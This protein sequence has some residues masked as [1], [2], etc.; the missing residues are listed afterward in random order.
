MKMTGGPDARIELMNDAAS[1]LLSLGETQTE[2]RL[3]DFVSLNDRHEVLSAFERALSEGYSGR[4]PCVIVSTD[5]NPRRTMLWVR[6]ITEAECDGSAG[7]CVIVEGEASCRQECEGRQAFSRMLLTNLAEDVLELDIQDRSIKRLNS[8]GSCLLQCPVNVRMFADDAIRAFSSRVLPDDRHSV[9][10]FFVRAMSNRLKPK[11]QNLARTRFAL[12][13]DDGTYQAVVATVVPVTSSKVFICLDSNTRGSDFGSHHPYATVRKHVSVRMFGSF[14]VTVDGKT[15][16][17][18]SEKARELLALLIEKRGA[19][20]TSR[21]AIGALWECAPDERSR[22]RYRKVASRL[23]AELGEMGIA[24]IV[25][26]ERGVRRV[27]P[28]FI[29]CDYYDYLDG[30]RPP[31]GAFLPEYSWSEYVKVD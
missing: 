20:L 11:H 2:H 25:E 31:S 10:D 4:V 1:E 7:F 21:E 18:K 28:E 29:E 3:T 17:F 19:H 26:S 27:I 24:Y 8:G 16:R 30:K 13:N 23:M 15:V 9:I 22:P 12:A 6:R 14:S 5:G